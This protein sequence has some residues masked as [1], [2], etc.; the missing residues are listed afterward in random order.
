MSVMLDCPTA[1][2]GLQLDLAWRRKRH[3]GFGSKC[4]GYGLTRCSVV[5]MVLGRMRDVC[6]YPS[7]YK[8]EDGCRCSKRERLVVALPSGIDIHGDS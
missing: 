4:D 6:S 7:S 5:I 1:R 2:D 8:S 3:R